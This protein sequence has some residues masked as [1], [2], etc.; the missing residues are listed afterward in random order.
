MTNQVKTGV[1]YTRSP[2][3]VKPLMPQ[4][5]TRERILDAAR[6]LFWERGYAATSVHDILHRA[7]A[8]SGS[9]YHFFRAKEDLL[10]AVL[11][12][13]V[14]ALH[15][16]II[17]PAVTAGTDGISRVFAVLDGYRR[18]LVESDCTY[19]CPIGRLALEIDPTSDASMTLIAK[20][21]VGW[22]KAVE[23]LLRQERHRFPSHT[24]FQEL[25]Q[26]VLTVMEG[27]VMQARAHRSIEPFDAAVRQLRRYFALLMA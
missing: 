15:P 2:D 19:G 16:V 13:Y 8:R 24:D 26:F 27:G 14:D 5:D 17:E 11:D 4:I 25:A 21:F 22:T 1:R 10:Q 20:N 23:D 12:I 7:K 18:S 9:F 3:T 6:H